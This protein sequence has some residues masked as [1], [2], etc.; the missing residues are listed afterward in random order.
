LIQ[1]FG[2]IR[3]RRRFLLPV[4]ER[5]DLD[6]ARR[7]QQEST[8][9]LHGNR[10]TPADAWLMLRDKFSNVD[11]ADLLVCKQRITW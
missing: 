11:S 10:W 1:K 7:V 8:A 9:T 5:Q 3:Q 4:D 2:S 6:H